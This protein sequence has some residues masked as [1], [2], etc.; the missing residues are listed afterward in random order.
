MKLIL[1]AMTAA[2]TL[3]LPGIAAVPAAAQEFRPNRVIVDYIE[4]RSRSLQAVMDRMQKRGVLEA[5]AQFLS[6]VRLPTALRL[7]GLECGAVNAYYHPGYRSIQACYEFLAYIERAAPKTVTPEGFTPQE[8][9]VGGFTSVLLHEAGHAMSDLLKLPVF[10]REEDS[11]DQMAQF[12]ALQFGKDVARFVTKGAAWLWLEGARSNPFPFDPQDTHS[13]AGERF[14]NYL[15]IAYG[16][17]PDTFRDLADRYLPKAR[18]AN[19][20]REYERVKFAFQKTILPYV[21]QELLKK[22]QDVKWFEPE[23]VK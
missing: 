19:C 17:E 2:L 20:S 16:G 9:L 21:D 22:N 11:A 18:A 4:P 8:A 6:P 1:S 14:H 10:G 3:A 23:G 13:T 5:L 12:V 7:W 15:C